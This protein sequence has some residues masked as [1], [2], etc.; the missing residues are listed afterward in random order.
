MSNLEAM[1]MSPIEKISLRARGLLRGLSND[2]SGVAAIEFA[3]IVPVMLLM[4]FGVVEFSSGVAVDR[5]VTLV[6]RTL[7]DLTSQATNVAD[8]DLTNAGQTAKAIMTPYS[9]VPLKSSITELYVDP[10]TLVARVQWSKALA[11]DSSG[12]VTF[13]AS[14]HSP[15]DVVAIPL[16]LQVGDTYLIWSEVS[17]NYVP[18][19]GY[20]MAKTGVPLSDFTYTRPRQSACVMYGTTVC[21]TL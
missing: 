18:A 6:A 1:M 17:Y 5:K 15:K 16:A 19:V 13:A 2:C 12:N 8:T 9:A 14:T 4:F 21:T 20:V 7:S 3:V 10:K 11:I